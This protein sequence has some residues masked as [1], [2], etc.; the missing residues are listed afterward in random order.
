MFS[1]A[2]LVDRARVDEFRRAVETAR[3]ARPSVAVACTGPWPPFSFTRP[4]E[5]A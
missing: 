4:L 3:A 5:A 2:Y 1:G